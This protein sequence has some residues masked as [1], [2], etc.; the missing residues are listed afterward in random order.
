ME[1]VEVT[2][3]YFAAW[4]AHDAAGVAGQF[5]ERGTY[6]DPATRGPLTGGA[7]AA[8]AAALFKAF[9]D[10]HFE[11]V[12]VAPSGDSTI[13]AQWMMRGTNSGP[14][15]GNPPSGRTV[16]LPG[17]DFIMLDGDRLRSVRGYFDQQ[18]FLEQLGMQVLP[19]PPAAGPLSFGWASRVQPGVP[20][21]PGAFSI[22][23]IDSRSNHEDKEIIERAQG[24]VQELARQPGFITFLGVSVGRRHHTITAWERPEDVAAVHRASAH[25]D[26]AQRFFQG[27]LGAATFSSVWIPAAVD[28]LRVRC[29]GCARMADYYSHDGRCACG[30]A[31]P[32]PPL[33]W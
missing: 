28:G 9:P 5:S 4:N 18:G 3:R 20:T 32:A 15:A 1:P 17:A 7:I 16:A 25:Q 31:L 22:T 10:V 11:M 27:E 2:E 21:R 19:L 14:L 23:W 13:A 26:A 6:E 8:Y 29:D 33:Y 12:S 30:R 24:V